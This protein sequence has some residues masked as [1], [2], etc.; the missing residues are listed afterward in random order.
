MSHRYHVLGLIVIGGALYWLA[1][2]LAMHFL[3]PEFSVIRSPM[4]AYVLGAYGSWMTSTYFALSTTL[5]CL[6]YGVVTTLRRRLLPRIA[7][8]LLLVASV[9]VFLAGV[10]PM[11][12]PPPIRTSSGRLHALGGSV[13]FPAMALGVFLCSRSFRR[14]DHW[15][16][17]SESSVALAAG[18]LGAF[19]LGVLSLSTLGFAGYAQRLLFLLLVPWM[20]VV[21][22]CLSRFRRSSE[23]SLV[24]P[25][26]NRPLQ[27]SSG[28]SR[29]R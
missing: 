7:S 11:D 12:F 16:R 22:L 14:D 21:G 15:G 6:A 25:Q 4:S 23:E 1:V 17:V 8:A 29:V 18:V 9:G 20:V 10:F 3:E 28:S 13:A 26:P 2:V 24:G 19:L 5:L 27:P